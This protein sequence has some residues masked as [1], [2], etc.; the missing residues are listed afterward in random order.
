MPRGLRI[1]AAVLDRE[2]SDLISGSEAVSQYL[3]RHDDQRG[4]ARQRGLTADPDAQT[5]PQPL[6]DLHPE[7]LSPCDGCIQ[8]PPPSLQQRPGDQAH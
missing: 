7:S 2:I 6:G 3:D 5:P 8:A 1:H 4:P